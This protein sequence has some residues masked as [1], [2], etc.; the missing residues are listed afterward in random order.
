MAAHCKKRR[1]RR[2]KDCGKAAP[3][4]SPPVA[5]DGCSRLSSHAAN[6]NNGRHSWPRIVRSDAAV[7]GKTVEK[8]LPGALHQ[9]QAM[10]VAVFHLTQQIE[11]TGGTHGRAL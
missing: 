11:I 2:R 10:V 3:G 1:C 7:G 4:R 9:S 5:G 8:P 6:R